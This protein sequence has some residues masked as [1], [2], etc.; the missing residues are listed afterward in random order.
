M[1]RESPAEPPPPKPYPAEKVGGGEIILKTRTRK[2]IFISGLVGAMLPR[3]PDCLC[4]LALVVRRVFEAPWRRPG[5]LEIP[6]PKPR[7]VKVSRQN[8]SELIPDD[9]AL[10]TSRIDRVVRCTLAGG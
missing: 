4:F 6:S 7:A 5:I 8:T 3:A 10:Q 9:F 1:V 2:A